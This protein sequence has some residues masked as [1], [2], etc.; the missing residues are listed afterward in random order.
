V[1]RRKNKYVSQTF[2]RKDD[3]RTWATEAERDIDQGKTPMHARV[4]RAQTFEDLIDLHIADMKEV[5]K[6]P[7]R[8][9]AATLD[10]LKRE[11]GA[12]RM[13]DLDRERLV[14]FGRTRAT[15]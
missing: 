14:K 3:A 9:K 13:A 12:L 15:Q 4:K 10:M 5:G 6:A 7:G 8:S 1:V 11:L 2:L